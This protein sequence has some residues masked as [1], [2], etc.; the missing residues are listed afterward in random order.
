MKVK[1]PKQTAA[2]S[3]AEAYTCAAGGVYP[4]RPSKDYPTVQYRAAVR[5]ADEWIHL[6]YFDTM[7]MARYRLNLALVRNERCDLVD[8]TITPDTKSLNAWR[9]KSPDN[10]YRERKAHEQYAAYLALSEEA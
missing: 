3:G 9:K 1:L 2:A 5:V 4:T 8:G 7:S 6:G 10:L